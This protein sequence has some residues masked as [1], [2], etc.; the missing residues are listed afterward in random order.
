[1]IDTDAM[2]F[3]G[4]ANSRIATINEDCLQFELEFEEEYEDENYAALE[5]LIDYITSIM[6]D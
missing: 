3:D 5:S 4:D 6:E 1:M 2:F